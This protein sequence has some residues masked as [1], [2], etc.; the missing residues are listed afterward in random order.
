MSQWNAG[1]WHWEE[2]NWSS[3]AATH[4]KEKL[5]GMEFE[6]DD[7]KVKTTCN[8]VSGDAYVN[9]RKGKKYMGYELK[10]SVKFEGEDCD[11]KVSGKVDMP[12]VCEDVDD[13]KYDVKVVVTSPSGSDCYDKVTAAVR[14]DAF[15]DVIKKFTEE[16]MNKD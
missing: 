10:I 14:K 3:W 15:I 12:Y 1:S 11:G 7:L 16:M 6:S 4:L 5:S 9:I 2:R 13:H 8:E